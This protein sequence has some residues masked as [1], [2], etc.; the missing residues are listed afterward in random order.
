MAANVRGTSFYNYRI[1]YIWN[2][3]IFKNIRIFFGCLLCCGCVSTHLYS[4]KQKKSIEEYNNNKPVF[5]F[6]ASKINLLDNDTLCDI[7]SGWGWSMSQISRN[8][9][10]SVTYFFEDINKDI[11]NKKIFK[12][13]FKFFNAPI[14][15]DKVHFNIGTKNTIP[16]S[17]NKF[18]K[19]SLFISLHEFDEKENML[20][21]INRIMRK[22][23]SF[24]LFENVYKDTVFRD[25]NCGYD[26]IKDT[27]LYKLIQSRFIITYDT[28]LREE[29]INTNIYSRFFICKKK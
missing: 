23:G 14:R 3:K 10:A 4:D 7:A 18:N 11:C 24:Y 26:Y 6:I 20:N 21:E 13:S 29:S 17:T 16:Y 22:D 9:P 12:Q 8:S 25:A 1:L 28:I 15:T 5:N 27:D 19:I 2:M